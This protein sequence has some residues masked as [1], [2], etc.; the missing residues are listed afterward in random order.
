MPTL[1]EAVRILPVREGARPLTRTAMPHQQLTQNAPVGLQEALFLRA[2]ALEGVGLEQSRVSVPGAR[3]FV[4][5]PALA[6]GPAEAFMAGTE[7]AHLH[8]EQDGSLHLCLPAGGAR[9]VE[10]KGWGELHPAAR[11]GR[12][13]PTAVMVFGPR[14]EDE[15][16]VVWRILQISHAFALGREAT[17]EEAAPP[18]PPSR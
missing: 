17:V 9:E 6:R 4:L 1:D 10:T 12:I 11:L 18:E 13:P 5:D 16:E 3:A 2:A 15:L 7:F 14:D 8:P